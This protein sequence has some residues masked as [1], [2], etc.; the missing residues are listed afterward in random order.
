MKKILLIILSISLFS[1]EKYL[2]IVPDYKFPAELATSNLDSLE[3]ITNGTFNQLQ[4]GNLFGG[5]LIANSELLAD[6]WDVPPISSFSL[7]QLRTREM[8][9]Y[10]GEATGLWNDGYRAINMANI[11]LHHLPEHQE[12]DIE[13]AKLLEGECLFIRAICHFEMLRMFSHENSLWGIPIRLRIGSATEGQNTPRS[14]VEE[15]Y[16]QIIQDLEASILLLPDNKNVRASKWAAIAYLSKI[17]FQKHN[18]SEAL[19]YCDQIINSGEFALNSTVDQIYNIT[20]SNFSGESIFQM[21]NIPEDMSNGTLTGRLKSTSVAYY[22]PFKNLIEVMGDTRH[23]ELYTFLSV[24]YLRKYS[25]TAM[26]ITIIRLAEIYLTRAE[27]KAI[28]GG[29]SD[30]EI[31]ED[32]NLIRVRA[33]NT[34]DN[35]TAGTENLLN[36]IHTERWYELGFEGDRFHDIKRRQEDFNSFIGDYSWDNPKLVYPIPQQEIDQNSNMIQNEG[37]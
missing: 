37:Y 33:N 11:V 21:I 5:G 13:K 7:N 18:Y 2:E 17:H 15:V 22:T 3:S 14:S 26:N 9:A 1:C 32:Y 10:N 31:R 23:T 4:S 29:Y 8:N 6:N 16:G 20:G 30:T 25:N 24:P 12:Q 28:V 19:V 27:C 36:A 34:A 35:L